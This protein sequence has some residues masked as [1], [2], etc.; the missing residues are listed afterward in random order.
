MVYNGIQEPIVN[1]D[2]DMNPFDSHKINILYVGRFDYQK[3]SIYYLILS[4]QQGLS[5]ISR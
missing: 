1:I 2:D 5:I 3:G 4:M